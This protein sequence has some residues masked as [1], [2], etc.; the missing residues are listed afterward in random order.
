MLSVDQ[1][2]QQITAVANF[3]KRIDDRFELFMIEKQLKS[4]EFNK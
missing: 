1:K 3:F 4:P 2:K